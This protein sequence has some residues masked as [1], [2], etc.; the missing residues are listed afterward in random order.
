MLL[1][2]LPLQVVAMV[3]SLS[4]NA[5]VPP[6]LGAHQDVAIAAMGAQV[7]LAEPVDVVL[8]DANHKETYTV[9]IGRDGS[10]DAAT[11]DTLEHAF[12]CRRSGHERRID[13][14]LLAMIADVQ[15]R[16]PGHTIEYISAHRKWRGESKTS[17]HRAGRALDFRVQGVKL[18]AVR[19]Y[20]WTRFEHVGVGWYP[21]EEF[22]HMDP[23]PQD[24]AW[25]E[26][27]G[28]NH[29]HP[30]WSTRLRRGDAVRERASR[31]GS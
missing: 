13:K 15:A 19:D 2:L 29:Y 20:V 22:V 21:N 11:R 5:P 16:W 7:A 17:P 27:R 26:V 30:S 28:K 10:V 8:Y 3:G 23:R 18:T 1:S 4:I 9:Q 6:P 24:L 25:T 31:I 12:R 14:G